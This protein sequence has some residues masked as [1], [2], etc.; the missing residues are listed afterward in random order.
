[1]RPTKSFNKDYY[2]GALMVII[3]LAAVYASIQYKLGTLQRMGPG[4][5]PCAVGALLALSGLLIALSARGE[6]PQAET[7][8]HHPTGL[9]DLRGGLCIVAGTV[10]FLVLGNY[11]GLLPATFAIVFICALGDRSN[12]VLQAFVLSVAMM[13]IATVVFWWALQLQL[14]LIKWGA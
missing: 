7:G 9:P 3:G 12:T 10:A 5:F 14:P 11:C 1:M 6:K 8:G 4:F 13:V 2:G